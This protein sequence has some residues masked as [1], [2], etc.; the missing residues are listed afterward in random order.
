MQPAGGIFREH[1]A[2]IVTREPPGS[3]RW[4][5]ARGG[6]KLVISEH[7]QTAGAGK[8]AAG[9]SAADN[10]S[11]EPARARGADSFLLAGMAS[12][13][14]RWARGPGLVAVSACGQQRRLCNWGEGAGGAQVVPRALS[15][16]RSPFPLG[17]CLSRQGQ[18]LMGANGAGGSLPSL[19]AAPLSRLTG[20]PAPLP[21]QVP[22]RAPARSPAPAP[23]WTPAPA[24]PRAALTA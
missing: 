3:C 1:P 19:L 23:S 8:E 13:V 18:Q 6:G 24:T 21:F 7:Q 10:Y 14:V 20:C 12:G 16:S 22:A 2:G 17:K 15:P 11:P 9:G 5:A 4:R